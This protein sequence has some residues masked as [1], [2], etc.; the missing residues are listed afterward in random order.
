MN[1]FSGRVYWTVKDRKNY[2]TMDFSNLSDDMV[3]FDM[4]YYVDSI[5]KDLPLNSVRVLTNLSGMKINMNT[6]NT[7]K[8]FSKKNQ[9]FI[10]KSAIIGI[11]E[12]LQP[13]LKIYTSFTGSKAS[14]FS[15]KE[16]AIT[17]LVTD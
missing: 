16:Q 4:V 6:F 9:Q 2:L 13:F 5:L 11:S 15:S 3:I 12:V 1:N 17:F 8:N 10:F 7:L 14:F